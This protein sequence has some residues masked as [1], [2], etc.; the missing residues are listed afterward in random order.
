MPY[1]EEASTLRR[2]LALISMLMVE[3]VPHWRSFVAY[4]FMIGGGFLTRD[5]THATL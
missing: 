1:F 3:D 2:L 5:A 4:L